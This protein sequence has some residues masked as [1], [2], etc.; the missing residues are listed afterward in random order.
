MDLDRLVTELL[1]QEDFSQVRDRYVLVPT[2]VGEIEFLVLRRAAAT[3]REGSHREREAHYQQL[4]ARPHRP[5]LTLTKFASMARYA[6]TYEKCL[7]RI[8][9]IRIPCFVGL[10]KES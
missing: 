10:A 9:R 5:F 4:P 6:T 2:Y 8:E 3:R 7:P 1:P